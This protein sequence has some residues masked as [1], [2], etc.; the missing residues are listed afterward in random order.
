MGNL[1]IGTVRNALKAVEDYRTP[2]RFAFSGARE[3]AL[4]SWSAPVLWRFGTRVRRNLLA[5]TLAGAAIL[6]IAVS[7]PQAAAV[8]K[9]TFN[10]RDFGAAGDGQCTNFKSKCRNQ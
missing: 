7:V 9:A 1:R 8:D 2:R 6:Q 4:A 5:L 10:V 3:G